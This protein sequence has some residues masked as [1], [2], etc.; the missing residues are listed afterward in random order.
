MDETIIYLKL[1][2]K[3]KNKNTIVDKLKN[4]K[5][6]KIAIK[7]TSIEKRNFLEV[8]IALGLEEILQE[9]ENQKSKMVRKW[10]RLLTKEMKKNDYSFAM[11]ENDYLWLEPTVA[12][13]LDHY[14][15]RYP[16]EFIVSMYQKQPFTDTLYIRCD[17]GNLFHITIRELME[18]IYENCNHLIIISKGDFEEEMQEL[19]D[20][21]YK[22]SGLLVRFVEELPKLRASEKVLDKKKNPP[23]LF[24]FSRETIVQRN[25]PVGITYIDLAPTKQKERTI[26]VKR[27]D[28]AYFNYSD[29]I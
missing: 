9:R 19:I 21:I 14:P 27:Q 28:I 5:T 13:T 8:E 7:R 1:L 15:K 22:D 23:L 18:K 26:R 16:T 17:R 3:E 2:E 11:R 12:E 25:L 24:D 29:F 20:N 10:N 6:N 4:R